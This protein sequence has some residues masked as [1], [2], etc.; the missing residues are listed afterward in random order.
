[1]YTAFY[2]IERL[3]GRQ[4]V[5]RFRERTS[6]RCEWLCVGTLRVRG[7]LK[8]AVQA[9]RVVTRATYK[10]HRSVMS[11]SSFRLRRDACVEQNLFRA[12][13]EAQVAADVRVSSFLLPVKLIVHAASCEAA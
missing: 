9:T 10:I 6:A 2:R 4:Q 1:M 7:D 11:D 3:S 13:N 8:R 12:A 5:A